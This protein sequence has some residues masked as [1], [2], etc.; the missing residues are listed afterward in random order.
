MVVEGEEKDGDTEMA[1]ATNAAVG[2]EAA[3]PVSLAP[4]VKLVCQLEEL[5]DSEAED[6]QRERMDRS[7]QVGGR[8]LPVV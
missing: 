8:A 2:G 3:G 6:K 5:D 7:A 1:D 4:P